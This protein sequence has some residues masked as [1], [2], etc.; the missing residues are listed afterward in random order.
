MISTIQAHTA[1]VVVHS[2]P[3]TTIRGVS[4]NANL[5]YGVQ[6]RWDGATLEGRIGGRFLGERVHLHG[7]GNELLGLIAGGI[8]NIAVRATLNDQQLELRAVG[9]RGEFSAEI[10]LNSATGVLKDRGSSTD[11]SLNRNSYNLTLTLSD[12]EEIQLQGNTMLGNTALG[13]AA[14]DWVVVTAALFSV[15]VTREIN[16]AQL[17]SLR[18][19]GEL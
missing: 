7:S 9:T 5:R 10:D 2:A 13:N 17:E 8:G 19:M 12:A 16:R 4:R 6:L 11:F 3:A 15:I 18:D 1:P 14:P